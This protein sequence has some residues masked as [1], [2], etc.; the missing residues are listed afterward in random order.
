MDIGCYLPHC[1]QPD[2]LFVSFF[3]KLKLGWLIQNSPSPIIISFKKRELVFAIWSLVYLPW[4][5]KDSSRC[6]WNCLQTTRLMHFFSYSS[7][8]SYSV[9]TGVSA[10]SLHSDGWGLKQKKLNS[11]PHLCFL[12][13]A[14]KWTFYLFFGLLHVYFLI[15]L[16]NSVLSSLTALASF[17]LFCALP[18][19][20]CPIY[21]H[22]LI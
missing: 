11:W 22:L 17:I 18:F 2:R 19:W 8:S 9:V 21:T 4:V 1:L 6:L 7:R 10:V 20:F 16:C 5:L 13:T 12:P 3:W 14:H 15:F